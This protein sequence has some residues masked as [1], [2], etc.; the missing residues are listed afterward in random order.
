MID[1]F[2]FVNGSI[3][4]HPVVSR[5]VRAPASV[6]WGALKSLWGAVEGGC[7]GEVWLE[8]E[9]RLAENSCMRR[10]GVPPPLQTD[11]ARYHLAHLTPPPPPNAAHFPP[12]NRQKIVYGAADAPPCSPAPP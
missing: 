5:F 4:W 9:R 10:D 1:L 11:T 3:S 8:A 7:H 6:E 12:K 2:F